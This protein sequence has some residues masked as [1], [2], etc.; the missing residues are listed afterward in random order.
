MI[1]RNIICISLLLTLKKVPQ[2]ELC[3]TI[4]RSCVFR[5]SSKGVI[6][7]RGINLTTMAQEVSSFDFVNDVPVVLRDHGHPHSRFLTGAL[8][9]DMTTQTRRQ[10]RREAGRCGGVFRVIRGGNDDD[11]DMWGD[12][13]YAE[14][15]TTNQSYILGGVSWD[16]VGSVNS[17]SASGSASAS[18]S[19]SKGPNPITTTSE[20][21]LDSIST[22]TSNTGPSNNNNKLTA[23]IKKTKKPKW[24]VSRTG[25]IRNVSS[26]SLDDDTLDSY[27][28]FLSAQTKNETKIEGVTKGTSATTLPYE[29]ME[30]D[31]EAIPSQNTARGSAHIDSVAESRTEAGPSNKT[32]NTKQDNNHDKANLALFKN[33]LV[34]KVKGMNLI[35]NMTRHRHTRTRTRTDGPFDIP[36]PSINVARNPKRTTVAGMLNVNK[37]LPC[38]PRL[39]T[40]ESDLD[41][42]LRP[43]PHPHPHTDTDADMH[44]HGDTHRQE[45]RALATTTTTTTTVETRPL[46]PPVPKITITSPSPAKDSL[47]QALAPA[48]ARDPVSKSESHQPPIQ[49]DNDT[50]NEEIDKD[51]FCSL[52]ITNAD[53][54]NTETTGRC[55]V[56]KQERVDPASSTSSED[57]VDRRWL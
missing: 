37:P 28:L 32:T 20:S 45:T 15:T 4:T 7:S 29:S 49:N 19:P 9:A 47:T 34:K 54:D 11:F 23:T 1:F 14:P 38:I 42:R 46:A 10:R 53:T 22:S 31:V 33:K 5:S 13:E 36:Q 40:T 30:M 35:S 39:M 57:N 3:L 27:R 16:D 25:E 26:E 56:R 2:L 17:S 8:T 48:L 18:S 52:P 41:L 6:V 24:R 50:W 51:F 21:G 44:T 12:F 43:H 55:V